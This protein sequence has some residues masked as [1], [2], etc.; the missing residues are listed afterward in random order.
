MTTASI[1]PIIWPAAE[2]PEPG[3]YCFVVTVGCDEDPDPVPDPRALTLR[4]YDD[5]I[6]LIRLNN[7]IT[8]KNFDV[9]PIPPPGTQIVRPFNAP[10]ALDADRPMQLEIVANLPEGAELSLEGEAKFVNALVKGYFENVSD[11][12]M[13]L[14][15]ERQG[16]S[17]F[18]EIPFPAGSVNPLKL[19][20]AF[21]QQPAEGTYDIYARQLYQGQ[22]IGRI[23]WQL[24]AQ[25]QNEPTSIPDPLRKILT[26]LTPLSC[27]L[28]LMF[29]LAILLVV[30]FVLMNLS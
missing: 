27:F 10:G 21:P 28:I 3:H 24:A 30:Y 20:A 26:Q 7:N 5:Y 25:T 14:P 22:E 12:R 18:N 17:R 8:W 1:G 13:T 23:T 15:L 2:L 6:D 9:V 16:V 19:I 29:V 11:A 4:D